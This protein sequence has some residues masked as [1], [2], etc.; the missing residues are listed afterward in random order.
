[1]PANEETYRSRTAMHV[2]FAISSVAMTLTIVWMILADHLRPWKETQR[3]FHYIEDAKLRKEKQARDDA[4]NQAQLAALDQRV[5]A[6][7]KQGEENAKQIR[8]KE[9]ELK[10]IAGSYERYDT[11]TRFLKAELDSRRSEYDLMIDRGENREA[12]NYLNDVIVPTEGRLLELRKEYEKIK[13][14]KESYDAEIARLRGNIAAI[15]KEK[16][17]LT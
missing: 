6:A 10:R 15:E 2:V 14:E 4:L 5:E 13:A 16:G 1:M 17:A 11:L 7:N 9:G 12:R 3:E 8:Q